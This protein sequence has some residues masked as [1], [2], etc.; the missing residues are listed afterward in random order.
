MPGV[1]AAIRRLGAAG[2][3]GVWLV[4]CAGGGQG[5][6][7][8]MPVPGSSASAVPNG[9]TLLRVHL[10]AAPS[11]AASAPGFA[12]ATPAPL[13]GAPQLLTVSATGPTPLTQTIPLGSTAPG[14]TQSSAGAICQATLA[15]APGTYTAVVSVYDSATASPATMIGQAQ[16]IA[17]SVLPGAGA[18]VNLAVATAPVALEVTAG[19]PIS[20]P[21]ASG[22]L[23]LYGAGKHA[24]VIEMLDAA[25][26]VVVGVPLPDFSVTQTGGGLTLAIA[27]PT[28]AQPNTFTL[29]PPA[30]WASGTAMLRVSASSSA[31]TSLN[32][33]VTL[34][35]LL[36]VANAGANNV[37]LYADGQTVPLQTLATAVNDPQA[38]VFDAQGDLFVASEPGSVVEYTV[39]YTGSPQSITAGVN[40]PQAL[41]LDA[42]GDLFVANG[43]GSNTVT[44]YAPPYTGGPVATISKQIN[45]PTS[46]GVDGSGNVLVVNQ[47][48]NSLTVYAPP[49]D[50]TPVSVTQ[51][52]SGPSSLAIDA[53]GDAFVANLTSTPNSVVMYQPPF[54][55]QSAPAATI[56]NGV[57]EQG[58]LGIAAPATLLVPNQGANTV[59]AY[60]PPYNGAPTAIVGGQSQPVALAVDASGN[61]FVANYGNNTVTEYAPPYASGSWTTIASGVNAPQALA[62]SPPT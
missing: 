12:F 5:L 43:S 26:N 51:G 19:S 15:L 17:F 58:Q 32:L 38:L 36:A 20:A 4:A 44:E 37:A 40:H 25:Q 29:T 33:T 14:C 48:A 9:A 49:Y 24:L 50:G 53:H 45:D 56:V 54:S 28:Q 59:T 11:A 18:V 42:R 1:I 35:Q 16:T 57:N 21:T 47:A 22:A 41:A 39:P 61:L 2:A 55:A 3:T 60:A 10:P 31:S 7:G 8:L 13:Q 46:V 52:L 62:L 34:R 27:Q 6:S 30:G 23:A